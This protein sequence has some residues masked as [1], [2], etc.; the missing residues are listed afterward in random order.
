MKLFKLILLTFVISFSFSNETNAQFL[1][2]LKKRVQQAAEE[3]IIDKTAEKAAQETAKKMDSLLEIDPN[4]QSKNQE[5]LQ[6][7]LYQSGE[8]I[9]VEE[10]YTFNANV[11][12]QMNFISDNKPSTIDYSMW[13][14]D[15]ENFMASEMKNITS[16]KTKDKQIPMGLMTIIDDKNKAMIMILEDQKIAQ[17]ISMDKIKEIAIEEEGESINTPFPNIKK[18]GKS[19]K[20]LGYYSE[21]FQTQTEDEIMS[22]WVTQDVKLYQ[23]NMFLNLSESLGGKKFQNIPNAAKGFMMELH[24]ENKS[25]GEK[26]SMVVTSISKKTKTIRTK[27]YQLMNLSGFMQK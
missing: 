8:N 6:K 25:N 7:M 27:D 23:K 1:K 12:Y 14:S 20:I 13:F 15:N 19:K 17:V 5:Q 4:Y 9:P 3:T 10:V 11:V 24:F 26:G 2:K 21:E 18:T 22:F 16:E